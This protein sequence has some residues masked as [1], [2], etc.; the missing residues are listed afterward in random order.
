MFITL[1]EPTR[2]MI[3]EAATAG[4]YEPKEIVNTYPRMQIFTIEELVEEKEAEYL[5]GARRLTYKQAK[6]RSK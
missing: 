5:C 4:L 3:E 6:S 2:L 1:Y